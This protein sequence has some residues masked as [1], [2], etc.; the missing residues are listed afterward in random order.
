MVAG[1]YTKKTS[2]VSWAVSSFGLVVLSG[3]KPMIVSI[4]WS[5]R[6]LRHG[7]DMSLVKEWRSGQIK[8]PL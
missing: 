2:G 5:Y 1:E 3:L 6:V 7:A 8:I 4:S